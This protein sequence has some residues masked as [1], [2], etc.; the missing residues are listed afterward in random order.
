MEA[1]TA[2]SVLRHALGGG[3][4]FF[5]LLGIGGKP[6]VV[7]T[8]AFRL[9]VL[10]SAWLC[11]VL[12]YT[13]LLLR[14]YGLL[15]YLH[16]PGLSVGKIGKHGARAA[17]AFLLCF[18][19]A[20][21]LYALAYRA[22]RGWSSGRL[23]GVIVAGGLLLALLLAMVYPIGATDV[24]DYIVHGELLTL[25]GLNP[26]VYPP[27]KAPDLPLI[28][29]AA[30]NDKVSPY[31]PIWTWFQAGVVW[32]SGKAGLLGLVLGFKALAISGYL[33]ACALIAIVLK[34]RAPR[35][36]VAGLLAFAW[37]PLVLFEVAT[38]AHAD[39][40]IGA[41][42]LCG[43]LFWELRRPLPMVAALMVA[44]LIKIPAAPLLP[45]FALAA[46][47]REPAIR[48]GRLAFTGGLVILGVAALSYLSLSQGLQGAGN[49]LHRQELFTHSLPAV[50]KL[51][52]ERMVPSG[53]A[54]LVVA[55]ATICAFAGY[56]LMQLRNASRT[57]GQVV[58]L[59]FNTLLFL[60]LVCMSWFQPWYL[61]WIMPLAA[62]YPRPDAPFQ[63]A[64][65]TMCV[66]F[67]YVLFG[68]VW[69]LVPLFWGEYLGINLAVLA[70]SYGLPWA[71][72][73]WSGWQGKQ[74]NTT[75]PAPQGVLGRCDISGS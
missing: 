37:N 44:P 73:L 35:Q 13:V 43:V 60:L 47:R 10:A 9:E 71:Y 16:I 3:T 61:L 50:L 55:S 6:G 56:F 58:R 54:A 23:V 33:V 24:F 63:V 75:K 7:L 62:V 68:F 32:A 45:L 53:T 30:Y 26:M 2:G 74:D 69:F 46:W 1:L 67:S 22:C 57:P 20:F 65:S 27:N 12:T 51:A 72:A 66:M 25:D 49:L 19:I 52:L 21:G 34:R 42:I 36:M 40:W 41:F 39:V 59:G 29:Y 18:L 15:A 14:P 64:L 5:V 28:R 48:R 17:G 8:S 11:S 31:G 70:T 4:G 38:N